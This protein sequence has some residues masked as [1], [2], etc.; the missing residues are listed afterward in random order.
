MDGM[1]RRGTLLF[2]TLGLLWGV[3]YAFI[4]VAVSELAPEAV[5]LARTAIAAA[6]LL[7]FAAFKKQIPLVMR[8]WKPVALYTLVEIIAPWYFINSAAQSLPSSTVGLLLA[9]VPIAGVAI[10]F[11]TRRADR[12]SGANWFGL[13]VGLS[14]VGLLV[15]FNVAGSDLAAVVQIAIAVVGYALGPAILARALPGVPGLGIAAVSLAGAALAYLPIVALAGSFPTRMPS[16]EVVVAVLVL[17]IACSALAF[18][19]MVALVA[20]VGP[21]RM[22]A[23]TYLNPAV[24]ILV[25]AA[26]LGE[27]ITH[28]TLIGFALVLAGSYLV[29]KR[30]PEVAGAP[31]TTCLA[32]EPAQ[33]GLEMRLLEESGEQGQGQ[34]PALNRRRERDDRRAAFDLG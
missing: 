8:H 26:W 16:T 20:E 31:A 28:W 4:A 25:G 23:I 33:H 27:R 7:P 11:L 12:M 29:T 14:G 1:T 10:A 13:L 9:T 32:I 17:A 15:G 19:V 6:V 3:P 2:L 30:A 24:A 18:M 21:V 22:T 34:D 5:V